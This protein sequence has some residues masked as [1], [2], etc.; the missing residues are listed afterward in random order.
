MTAKEAKKIL[1]SYF[2]LSVKIECCDHVI[3]DVIGRNWNISP[4][5]RAFYEKQL[6]DKSAYI[7]EQEQIRNTIERI[8][9]AEHR[10]LLRL[11][12]IERKRWPEIAE[13]LWLSDASC[14]IRK[15]RKTYG[16]FAEQWEAVAQKE[17]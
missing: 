15:A 9:D 10:T 13:A 1:E 16:L 7:R 12:F 5:V 3:C 4:S 17:Q 8:P 2:S 6:L 11:R 14:A